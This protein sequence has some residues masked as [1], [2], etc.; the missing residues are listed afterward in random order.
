LSKATPPRV[1]M[2]GVGQR[3]LLHLESLWKLQQAGLAQ[4][5]A[6]ADAYAENLS[7]AR[8]QRTIPDYRQGNIR[9]F[10]HFAPLLDAGLDALYICIPPNLHRGEVVQAAQQGIHLLV[11]K[12]MSLYLDQA[13]E[14]AEAIRTSGVIASVGFQQRFDAWYHAM[15]EFLRSKRTVQATWVVCWNIEDHQVKATPAEQM[16]GPATRVWT[17]FRAWSGTSIVEAGIHQTDLMRYW[18]GDIAWVQANYVHRG[19]SAPPEEGDN[20]YAYSVVYGFK[21][22]AV[23]NLI[24]S[25]LARVYY[26]EEYLHVLWDHG[27]LRIEEDGPTSYYYDGPYPPAS[28]PNAAARRHP[29][30]VPPQRGDSTLAIS[31]TFLTAVATNNRSLIRSPFAD[32]MNSLT[33]VLAANAS[34]ALD[35]TKIHLSEFASSPSFARFRQKQA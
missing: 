9:T 16:G 20:P 32:A 21:N 2:L 27:H 22:G 31:R 3:G 17:A 35:G 26:R 25:R 6:L 24:F 23:G 15:H 19:P 8:I 28:R 34:D 13:L 10:T 14:M 29:L 30:A 7:E 5:V 33:A 12:P 18:C 11:E 4:I 1:G